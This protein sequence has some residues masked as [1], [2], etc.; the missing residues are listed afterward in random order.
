MFNR[1]S[2]VSENTHNHFSPYLLLHIRLALLAL[3]G[4]PHAKRHTALVKCLVGGQGHADLVP[5][6]KQEE[7]PLGAIDGHLSDQLI[8]NETARPHKKIR[9]AKQCRAL[10]FHPKFGVRSH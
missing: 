2:E 5:D 7:T 6:T 4:L 8:C 1:A 3:Q 9:M 10:E